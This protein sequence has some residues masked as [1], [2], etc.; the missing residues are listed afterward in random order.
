[1]DRDK[2]F[3]ISKVSIG[4]LGRLLALLVLVLGVGEAMAVWDGKTTAEPSVRK[5]DGKDYYIIETEEHLAWFSAYTNDAQNGKTNVNARIEADYL[6]MGHKPFT[7]IAAGSGNPRFSG[8]FDGNNVT[9]KNLYVD[10]DSLVKINPAYGQNIAF[11]AVLAGT[12]KNV[13][14][15]DADI[16]ASSNIGSIIAGNVNKISVGTIVGWASSGLVEGCYAS[17]IIY[18]SGKGQAVGGIIGNANPY[19]TI[20]DC[21]SVVT[22]NIAGDN[23]D[24][25]GIIG[26]AKSNVSI[27]SCV[28]D[29]ARFVNDVVTSVAGGVIGLRY[30]S[31]HAENNY[32]DNKTLDVGVAQGESHGVEGKYDLNTRENACILNGGVWENDSCSTGTGVWDNGERI[33]NNGVGKDNL[34]VTV[35][36]IVFD[37]NGGVFPEGAK[38]TKNLN[39]NDSLTDKE[40]TR[41]YY[42]DSSMMFV[43]WAFTSDA[44][45]PLEELGHVYGV[46]TVYAVWREMVDIEFN[47]NH[48]ATPETVTKKIGLGELVV[49]V[50]A[51]AAYT[52]GGQKYYFAGWALAADATTPLHDYGVA[53]AGKV[54]YAVWSTD[55]TFTVSFKLN[56]HG[57]NFDEQVKKDARVA[58]PTVSSDGF[59]FVGWYKDSACTNKFDFSTPITEDIKL[60]A[61]WSLQVFKITYHLNGGENAS[62]NPSEYDIESETIV[63]KNPNERDGY[64]FA[65]WYYDSLFLEHATQITEGSS[66]DVSVYAKWLQIDYLV[67]YVAGRHGLGIVTSDEKIHGETLIL[68]SSKY[69][70]YNE[71]YSISFLHEGWARHDGGPMVYGFGSEYSDDANITLYPYWS[72]LVK[73]HYG[74][75]AKDTVWVD[76]GYGHPDSLVSNAITEALLSHKPAIEIP[77]KD[78]TDKFLYSLKW[79]SD[80]LAEYEFVFDSVA[81]KGDIVVS[82]GP[83]E[84]DTIH[85]KDTGFKT[86]EELQELIKEALEE[87]DPV[88]ALPTMEADSLYEYEFAKFVLNTE[89]GVYEA[90]FVKSGNRVFK[91]NF[92]LPEGAR[93]TEDFEGYRYGEVTKLPGARMQADETW[94]FKGWYTKSKGRG[95][96]VKMMRETDTG[97][98]SLYPLFQKTLRYDAN[99]DK[100]E[101]EVIYTDRA[102]ITIERALA[103]VVPANFTKG[104]KTYTFEKWVL[105]DGVYTAK[106]KAVGASFDVFAESRAFIVENARIGARMMLFDMDG[107]VV[108][109]GIISNASQRVEVSKPG[110]Y[111]VRINNEAVQVNVK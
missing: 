108:K 19:T 66:G 62:G 79:V 90:I 88:I 28:Y 99:G 36:T 46:D 48:G 76:I 80:S 27:I 86:D 14:L 44:T 52:E 64:H 73:V 54:Y 10:S 38:T 96:R 87:H 72:T 84:Q 15:E 17:G 12:V 21:L 63:F 13:V 43:G 69:A 103:D 11:I 50:A 31:V 60:Y 57:E 6:D 26:Q 8:T 67:A 35:F 49:P 85:I 24:V 82:Y 107:R 61:K 59:V 5:I 4:K 58:E 29:S 81:R 23:A 25:G 94:I 77:T 100:G 106:F 33:T 30:D 78:Y 18:N 37:A 53:E 51:P 109:R 75:E 1:M 7:P 74:K 93:L 110:S 65:G 70:Y 111:T 98:K 2:V 71:K 83:G 32:Y 91:I 9:V 41:P 89:T 95:E 39:F 20:K 102:D 3:K 45:E 42:A 40:I 55:P 47:F 22:I 34:D 101:I 105:K 16:R 56:G 104:K 92:H 97:N 68:S